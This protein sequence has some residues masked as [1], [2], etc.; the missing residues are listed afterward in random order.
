MTGI[1]AVPP[2][3]SVLPTSETRMEAASDGADFQSLLQAQSRPPVQ[4][5]DRARGRVLFDNL[6]ACT[7]NGEK[8]AICSDVLGTGGLN[9]FAIAVALSPITVTW[10]PTEIVRA[11]LRSPRI[12]TFR[13]RSPSSD[14]STFLNR[15]NSEDRGY[16]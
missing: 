6:A 16:D 14:E 2:A 3:P 9:A 4:Q 15:S 5:P 8:R 13:R 7:F 12:R 1:S 11:P 10:V